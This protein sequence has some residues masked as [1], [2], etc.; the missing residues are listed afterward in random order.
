MTIKNYAINI[1]SFKK[2]VHGLIYNFRKLL[3]R[4]YNID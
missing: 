2:M 4:T 1:H 3:I